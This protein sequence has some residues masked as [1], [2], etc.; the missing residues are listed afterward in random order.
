[1]THREYVGGPLDGSTTPAGERDPAVLW[2]REGPVGYQTLYGRYALSDA[3][4][5]VYTGQVWA[6]DVTMLDETLT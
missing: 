1:M 4:D 6:R 2:V 3:G 5:W